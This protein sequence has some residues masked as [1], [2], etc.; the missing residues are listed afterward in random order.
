MWYNK[1]SNPWFMQCQPRG[2][3]WQKGNYVRTGKTNLE[4]PQGGKKEIDFQTEVRK[5]RGSSGNLD[6]AL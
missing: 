6:A 4:S 3:S 1:E 5:K 2:V